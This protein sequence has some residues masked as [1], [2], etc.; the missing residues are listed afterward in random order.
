MSAATRVVTRAAR[1]RSKKRAAKPRSA[2]SSNQQSP[3]RDSAE[4]RDGER[5][6]WLAKEAE[7]FEQG[8]AAD[9]L[10][11]LPTKATSTYLDSQFR[12][13]FDDRYVQEAPNSPDHVGKRHPKILYAR[14]NNTWTEG[15]QSY[16]EQ[17]EPWVNMPLAG[18]CME[19]EPVPE[20]EVGRRQSNGESN[21]AG[22]ESVRLLENGSVVTAAGRSWSARVGRR[23]NSC[24]PRT[25]RAHR[26]LV[27]L[28]SIH[29]FMCCHNPA[30]QARAHW[31]GHGRSFFLCCCFLPR[32]FGM[33]TL[34]F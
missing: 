33:L 11:R 24:D 27:F 34:V 12:P 25:R 2:S 32:P 1:C 14:R 30:S 22:I 3:Q 28:L 29:R 10:L 13:K 19:R 17:I 8:Q 7:W 16:W 4:D 31:A 5:S 6:S 21:Q 23:T 20:R 18:V 9:L 26:F 15:L